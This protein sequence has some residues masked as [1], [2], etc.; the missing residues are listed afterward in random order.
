MEAK[1]SVSS[2][3]DFALEVEVAEICGNWRQRSASIS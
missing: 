3:Y 1:L 2:P